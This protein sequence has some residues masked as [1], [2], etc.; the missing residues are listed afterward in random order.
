MIEK[1]DALGR[2]VKLRAPARRIVSLVPSITETLFALGAGGQI[3]GVT[4][5]CIHPE[6]SVR[7]KPRV[8]GTKNAAIDTILQLK[9]DLVIANAEENR[10]H[11]VERL[12]ASGIPVFVTFPK[13]IDGCLKMISDA[14]ALS[15]CER[16][17]R[18]LMRSIEDARRTAALAPD[19]PRPRVLCP[20]W[21]NPYMTINRDT[22]VDDVI[23]TAGGSNIFADHSDRYPVF[24]LDE[25]A[26]RTPDVVLL[27]TEP[28]RFTERDKADFQAW[29]TTVAAIRDARV[30]VVEGELLSWYGPRTARALEELPRLL[31]PER[32]NDR[33]DSM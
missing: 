11:Q 17:A 10:P 27:P 9:P 7:Q 32:Q 21:K 26:A 4:D 19:F 16:R 28:Y 8:G 14:G 22:F 18:E 30:H 24:T 6:E 33:I 31:H 29:G 5:Y 13:T 25:A 3:A 20:I 2:A 23:R 1:V 15:G 12:E